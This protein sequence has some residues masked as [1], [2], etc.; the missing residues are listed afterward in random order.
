[1]VCI[2]FTHCDSGFFYNL[3]NTFFYFQN[4]VAAPVVTADSTTATTISLSWTS[5]GS[6]GV[7]Y[8]VDWQRV[9]TGD[10]DDVDEDSATV[11]GGSMT[12]YTVTGVQEDSNYTITVRASNR[13]GSERSDPITAMTLT[14]G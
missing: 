6:E 4:I 7:S 9:T 3:S 11:V 5:G 13:N 10:C 8:V 2:T 14:A 1:M 12:N